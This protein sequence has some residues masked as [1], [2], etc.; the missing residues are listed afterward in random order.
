MDCQIF[1][2]NL[3]KQAF[4]LGRHASLDLIHAQATSPVS[5]KAKQL[6]LAVAGPCLLGFY[7]AYKAYMFVHPREVRQSTR[8]D[9]NEHYVD[10]YDTLTQYKNPISFSSWL[11]RSSVYRYPVSPIRFVHLVLLVMLLEKVPAHVWLLIRV[12]DSGHRCGSGPGPQAAA[13][14]SILVASSYANRRS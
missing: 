13:P 4:L 3:G 14:A 10:D 2:H 12:W 7:F 6:G 8:E 5:S 1:A 11:D 9:H